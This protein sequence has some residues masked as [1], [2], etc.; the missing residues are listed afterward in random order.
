M[1]TNTP[2]PLGKEINVTQEDPTDIEKEF[3][4][5]LINLCLPSPPFSDLGDSEQ[6][7]TK[8][9]TICGACSEVITLNNHKCHKPM[10]FI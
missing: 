9:N 6:A 5:A 8:N 3:L 10:R 7:F 2:K 4:E 1:S